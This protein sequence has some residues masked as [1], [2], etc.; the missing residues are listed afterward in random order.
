MSAKTLAM[1]EAEFATYSEPGT[2]RLSLKDALNQ[3]LA[4]MHGFGVYRALTKE[5]RL[6]PEAGMIA[7]PPDCDS[8]L[9]A[10]P[11]FSPLARTP[12]SLWS[13][14]LTGG[15]R[16]DGLVDAGFGATLFPIKGKGYQTFQFVPSK[17]STSSTAFDDHAV[18]VEGVTEDG[19]HMVATVSPTGLVEFPEPVDEITRVVGSGLGNRFDLVPLV[20]EGEEPEAY[21]INASDLWAG[22][23]YDGVLAT[24]SQITNGRQ[25]FIIPSQGGG[26]EQGSLLFN[27]NLDPDRW[28]VFI[29]DTDQINPIT[30][31]STGVGEP[32]DV[33]PLGGWVSQNTSLAPGTLTLTQVPTNLG[34]PIS[35]IG[36]GNAVAQIRRYRTNVTWDAL[37]KRAFRPLVNPNDVTELGNTNAVK[38]GLLARIAEDNADLERANYHWQECRNALNEEME[39]ARGSAIPRVNWQIGPVPALRSDPT[40]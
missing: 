33:P 7:L 8:I 36:P 14:F 26:Y 27:T 11:V 18:L 38:H 22:I 37:C 25:S 3:A 10:R 4:R 1:L 28:V 17:E 34:P 20:F 2:G 24:F 6:T 9:F 40:Y 31:Y 15:P 5:V 13:D 23:D 12:D 21:R 39:S 29:E 35:R 19:Q 32:E 30:W 16:L